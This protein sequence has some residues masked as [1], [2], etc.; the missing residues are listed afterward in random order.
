MRPPYGW[1]NISCSTFLQH[2]LGFHVVGFTLETWDW[3]YNTTSTVQGSLD[4][5]HAYLR[6]REDRMPLEEYRSGIVLMHMGYQTTVEY[7]APLVLESFSQKGFRFV[8]VAECLGLG[9]ESWYR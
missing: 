8:S 6:E 2:T 1:C 3:H 5:V 9:P 4:I 7:V